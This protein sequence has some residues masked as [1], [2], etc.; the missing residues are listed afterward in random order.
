MNEIKQKENETSKTQQTIELIY[1]YIG[2]YRH[3][4]AQR[5]KLIP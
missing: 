5:T 1:I 3:S 4:T 2:N